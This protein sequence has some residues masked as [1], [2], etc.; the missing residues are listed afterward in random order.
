MLSI[1]YL[2]LFRRDVVGT[3]V[4][5]LSGTDDVMG[6]TNIS[7]SNYTNEDEEVW[8]E[9]HTYRNN[10]HLPEV[11]EKM[12]NN[13]NAVSIAQQVMSLITPNSMRAF[14]IFNCI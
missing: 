6:L 10:K 2:V 3:D 7:K 13:K 4:F 8:A 5:R 14:G 9:L 1:L 12:K 11:T